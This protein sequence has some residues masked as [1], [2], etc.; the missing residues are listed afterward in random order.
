VDSLT[1]SLG[2]V[3]SRVYESSEPG[4]SIVVLTPNAIDQ[5]ASAVFDAGRRGRCIRRGPYAAVA[6]HL[7]GKLGY[8]AASSEWLTVAHGKRTGG[9]P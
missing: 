3:L 8:I 5:R 7:C 2:T 4:G 6:A 9:Q 1:P